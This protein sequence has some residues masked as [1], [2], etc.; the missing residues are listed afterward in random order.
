MC[1]DG[2]KEVVVGVG[3]GLGGGD[4]DLEGVRWGGGGGGEGEGEEE[5]FVMAWTGEAVRAC[6]GGDRRDDFEITQCIG[7]F[8][9]DVNWCWDAGWVGC[10]HDVLTEE[11][12]VV[13]RVVD[14]EIGWADSDL[15]VWIAV[16]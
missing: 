7:L 9:G 6:C 14:Y 10:C 3:G 11:L 13:F 4:G 8:V 16:G 1:A 2:G 15:A 5:M 12:V